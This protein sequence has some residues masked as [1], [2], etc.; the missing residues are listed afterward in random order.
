M[1]KKETYKDQFTP[2]KQGCIVAGLDDE[3]LDPKKYPLHHILEVR[4]RR[5]SLVATQQVLLDDM[6]RMIIKSMINKKPSE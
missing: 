1:Q 4:I 6:K 2:W 3:V 5:I